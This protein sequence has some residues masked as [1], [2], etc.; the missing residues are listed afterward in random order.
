[1]L[2]FLGVGLTLI[3]GIMRVVNFAHGTLY[4]RR[5]R[6]LHRS[7]A[8]RELLG[9]A[10]RRAWFAASERWRHLNG[11]LR[12][13]Y[14]RD[15]SAFLMVTFGLALALGEERVCSGERPA[16]LSPPPSL[17]GIVFMLD[18]PFPTYRLFLIG[19]AAAV[20]FA[21]WQFLVRTRLGLL[22]RAT[23]QIPEMVQA[24]G[25]DV[26]LVR[27]AVFASAVASPA[28]G[29]VLAAPLLTA[30]LG[31]A[32]TTII[33]AFVIVIIGGMGSF[34]GSLVASLLVGFVQVFGDILPARFCPGLHISFDAAGAGN[35]PARPPRHAA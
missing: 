33:D 30:T 20:A 32:A 6:G 16:L 14:R 28:L 23:A 27:L 1:M 22:I 24:T 12:R 34:A 11:L 13:L 10:R 9:R 2:F 25:T 17:R 26:G 18:Q 21:L 29:G 31:L 3:F 8:L 35:A 4:A 5:L 19:F 15:D 7:P